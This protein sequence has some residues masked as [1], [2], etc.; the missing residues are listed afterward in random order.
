MENLRLQMFCVFVRSG[1]QRPKKLIGFFCLHWSVF[2]SN[3]SV[4]S[5]VVH[6]T[7]QFPYTAIRQEWR[8]AARAGPGAK[9]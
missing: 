8:D 2:H 7:M 1:D 6:L 5:G 3:L 9:G 4:E